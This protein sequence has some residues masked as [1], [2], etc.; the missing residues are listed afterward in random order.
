MRTKLLSL[1]ALLIGLWVLAACST[2]TGPT[3]AVL[4]AEAT[5]TAPPPTLVAPTSTAVPAPAFTGTFED[6]PCP[7]A[8]P[9]GAVEGRDIRCGYVA[10]PERHVLPQGKTIQLAVAVIP[11]TSRDPA[12]DP[13]VMLSGGPGES[14]LTAFT[15]LLGL[16]GMERLWAQRDVVLVEQRGTMYA[17]PFLQCPDMLAVKLE[18]MG[19]NLS[20][21]EED[22]LRLRAWADCRDQF[23]ASGVDLAAYNS[24]ENAA[25]IVTVADA[26]GYEQVNLYGGSYGSLLAQHVMR[27]YPERVRSAVLSDVSPLRHGPNMREKALSMD[28]ALRMLFAQ[29]TA[30]EACN[31]AYPDLEAVYWDLVARL[32]ESPATLQLTDPNTGETHEMVL[33]GKRLVAATRNLLYLAAALPR[34]PSAIYDM[35]EGDFSLVALIESR[36]TFSLGLADGMYNSVVCSELADVSRADVA[37]LE[38]VYPE[39]SEVVADLVDDVMLQPCPVWGVGYLGDALDQSLVSEIP[40]LLLSGEF[41]PTVP[42]HLAEVAAEGL[43]NAH[44][45]TFPGMSHGILGSGECAHAMMLA[46]LDD[47]AQAPDASCLDA[48]PGLAFH[49]PPAELAL[50]PFVDETRGFRGLVPSGWQEL[51]PANLARASSVNDPAYFVL[52]AQPVSAAELFASLTGQLG[53]DPEAEPAAEVPLGALTWRLYTFQIQSNP[54]DL[55]LAEEEGKAYFVLLISPAGEHDA[56]YEQLFLPAVEAM[57]P[58]G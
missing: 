16:P 58:L 55:A 22:T 8:L 51:R 25:D 29:C 27:D 50:E 21:E 12:P 18:I 41:D 37:R 38:G 26:L 43:V 48:M 9:E 28:R 53:L 3:E 52:E 44:L 7:M 47:P 33:T 46:F 36:F 6:A 20:E 57:G 56:L 40:T 1:A 5:P 17:T 23:V 35:A 13:L 49:V 24:L 32:D 31:Q 14:A 15:A 10:V 4:I 34:L 54:L 19:Q 42:P 30:E 45:Y 11:S 39:V 2:A